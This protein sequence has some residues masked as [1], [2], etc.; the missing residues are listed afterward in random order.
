MPPKAVQTFLPAAISISRHIF[1]VN[2]G[3]FLFCM[4]LL[5]MT[6]QF[7]RIALS[8]LENFFLVAYNMDGS[9]SFL[10]SV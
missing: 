3:G 10:L 5:A 4:L 2:S 6:G 9:L 1:V 8:G 7:C